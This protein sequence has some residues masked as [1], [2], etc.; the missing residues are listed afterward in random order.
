[1]GVAGS[2]FQV[3]GPAPNIEY[4]VCVRAMRAGI[5][6]FVLFCFCLICSAYDVPGIGSRIGSGIYSCPLLD[7]PWI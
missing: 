1:M 5:Y 4:L 6:F 3:Q 7:S 2:H